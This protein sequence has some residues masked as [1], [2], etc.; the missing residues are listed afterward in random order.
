MSNTVGPLDVEELKSVYFKF[1]RELEAG[2]TLSSAVVTATLENGVDD[3]PSS[4]LSG[5]VVID[6]TLFVVEQ[7]V[8]AAADKANNRYLLRCVANGST[9]RK[10]TMTTKMTV[11]SLG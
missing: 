1:E 10:H 7:R 3:T 4:I 11:K 6:N 5:A 9:G 2:E 8:V